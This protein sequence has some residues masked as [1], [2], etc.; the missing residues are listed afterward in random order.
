MCRLPFC[1]RPRHAYSRK[2][3]SLQVR[4]LV[5][6]KFTSPGTGHLLTWTA[7]GSSVPGSPWRGDLPKN[8]TKLLRKFKEKTT[9]TKLQQNQNLYILQQRPLL[10]SLLWTLI[11]CDMTKI[12]RKE[13]R[14]RKK[15]KEKRHTK[16]LCKR[17]YESTGASEAGGPLM[18]YPVIEPNTLTQF[19]YYL[20]KWKVIK[21]FPFP[22]KMCYLSIDII[23]R[24]MVFRWG[25]MCPPMFKR[26]PSVL[27]IKL[28]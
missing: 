9:T 24:G 4:W 10:P 6:S 18:D 7:D 8:S 17:R 19:F 14:K 13:K 23:F 16:Q 3:A 20:V 2:K 1:H 27:E 12:W 22:N 21:N 11:L 25:L 5:K 26:L 28:P 15:R